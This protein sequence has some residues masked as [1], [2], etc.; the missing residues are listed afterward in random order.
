MIPPYRGVRLVEYRDR[1]ALK[2]IAWKREFV[3]LFFIEANN[4]EV[5]WEWMSPKA[6]TLLYGKDLWIILHWEQF[7]NGEEAC[8]DI[9]YLAEA[10]EKQVRKVYEGKIKFLTMTKEELLAIDALFVVPKEDRN[11]IADRFPDL[12]PDPASIQKNDLYQAR[13]K[14]IAGMS[15]KTVVHMQ[16]A[17]ASDNSTE[18]EYHEREAVS[19]YYAE[20][21]HYWA[22][23]AVTDWQRAN[24]IG[25]K[26]I[27]EFASIFKK[28][29][30]EL[31]HID[32]KIV[33][34]WLRKG[35]NLMT[36]EELSKVVFDETG[37]PISADAIKKRRERLGLT[38]ERPPGPR[39]NSDQ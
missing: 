15:P 32:H 37:K 25:R 33:L 27:C 24:P 9:E 20:M 26:W 14:V 18:K 1:I 2:P 4:E 3:A 29:R 11:Y 12:P 19:A 35:Y 8:I 6:V 17:E 23:D 7:E 10:T 21:A 30:R 31:D 39:P 16:A 13:L 28:P 5:P 36:A 34:N 22:S 38:T